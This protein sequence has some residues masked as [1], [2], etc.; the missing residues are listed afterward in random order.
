MKTCFIIL[1]TFIYGLTFSQK[2][3]PNNYFEPPLKIPII[4]SGTFGEL[5]SNHFHS[6]IDIKTQ[7]KEG[8]PIY[9]PADG[10]VS[11]I[12][13]G[14]YGFGKTLYINHPNGYSTVYA[15][16][17]KY[18]SEIQS[19]IKKIQYQKKSY[20]TGN[21]F[22][23]PTKF[24][25]KKGQLIG[26]TG[27]TGSSLGPHLHYEIR[28]TKTEKIINPMLFGLTATDTKHPSIEKLMVFP[29]DDFSRI[30][31]SSKKTLIPI[32]KL[33]SGNYLAERF[34]AN[35]S[36]GLGIKVFD[37]L[38]F[39]NNKNG[40]YSLEMKLNG[41]SVYYHDLKTFS[42]SESK[43]INLLIDYEH[44]A[45]Y[46][47]RIQKTYRVKGNG[48]SLYKNLVNDG[49]L[50][51]EAGIN[52]NVEIIAK[53]FKGNIS[54]LKIPIKGVENN[55]IFKEKDTTAYKIIAEN[56]QKFQ[57]KNVTVAFPKNTFYEDTYINFSV[58]SITKIHEPVIPLDK[59]YTLTFNTIH[60]S[61]KQKRQIYIANVTKKKYPYYVK[62]RKKENKVY[63]TSKTLGSYQLK[64]DKKEP[65]V[66]LVN[67]KNNQWI[68]ALKTLKIKIKDTES[69]I[70][71]WRAT[72]DN[73]WILMEYN[74]RKGILTYDFSDK[75][76]IGA[77]HSFKITVS[78][79]V[80]NTK[81]VLATFFKKN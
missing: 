20:Q 57:L 19:F 73:E 79:N 54:S 27:N 71:N 12:K 46:K 41:E 52:Y 75:K 67:F 37:Q 18:S 70:K 6:G 38:N 39:A 33:S 77:K 23:K 25:L 28:D 29:L 56:F 36:I 11:R 66:S 50:N 44:Y 65:E 5:R 68:S 31:Q 13:V 30:N 43:Y 60:L 58:D 8:I 14:Q 45:R 59:R 42:F 81:T 40:I 35:G 10:Y 24:P 64:F 4:L 7:G 78:D 15:H 48:L 55:S 47:N 3:Y 21:I 53:D 62:T 2:K 34:S 16:L 9:A 1:L 49:K 80:G 72:I 51:I 69:G 32:K 26:Y 63:T 61:D 17:Q 22:P 74:H 76:L